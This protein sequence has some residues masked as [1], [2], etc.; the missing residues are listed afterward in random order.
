MKKIK[1][2]SWLLLLILIYL[3]AGCGN[4]PS[5][6]ESEP[7]NAVGFVEKKEILFIKG[8]YQWHQAIADAPS[9]DNLVKNAAIYVVKPNAELTLTFKGEEPKEIWGGLWENQNYTPLLKEKN[10][11]RLPSKPGIY[12]L[13]VGGKWSGDDRGSYAAAV[14]VKE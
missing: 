8:S 14:E 1:G 4:T 13:T 9:P 2:S 7:P 12:V 10:M 11:I 3:M 6:N 5:V